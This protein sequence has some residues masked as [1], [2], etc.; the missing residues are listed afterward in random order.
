[1]NIIA[2]PIDNKLTAPIETQYTTLNIYLPIFSKE[3]RLLIDCYFK[4]NFI[5]LSLV[6]TIHNK[7]NL[8][9]FDNKN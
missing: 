1:M 3:I 2:N 7:A 4:L 6:I 5:S 9:N 8:F